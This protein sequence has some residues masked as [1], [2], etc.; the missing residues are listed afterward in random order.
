[1]EKTR[2]EL[3]DGFKD[4]AGWRLMEHEEYLRK[5]LNRKKGG[6]GNG[7]KEDRDIKREN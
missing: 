7:S 4:T 5:I 1:M 2:T 6:H 3:S